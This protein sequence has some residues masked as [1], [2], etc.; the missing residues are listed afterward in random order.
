MQLTGGRP[1]DR[2]APPSK[3]D[4]A[5]AVLRR[6]VEL[7]VDWGRRRRGRETVGRQLL[8]ALFE[9]DVGRYA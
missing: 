2:D 5:I 1:V 7:G 9:S 8:K 6:A 3:R 4:E